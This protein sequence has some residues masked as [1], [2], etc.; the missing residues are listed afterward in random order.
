MSMNLSPPAESSNGM[1]R[2]LPGGHA[3]HA[4]IRCRFHGE[5]FAVP[6]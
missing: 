3:E 5:E 4:D 2:R 1:V 6:G